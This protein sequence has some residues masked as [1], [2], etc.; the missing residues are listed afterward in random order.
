[1]KIRYYFV[2]FVCL[3]CIAN[4]FN[5]YSSN[6]NTHLINQIKPNPI[7]RSKPTSSHIKLASVQFLGKNDKTLYY[8]CT[9]GWVFD[10]IKGG[11]KA[12]ECNGYPYAAGSKQAE[13]CAQQEV[14]LSGNDVK[15][16]CLECKDNLEKDGVGGCRCNT[17]D[18]P[19]NNKNAPCP[20]NASFD[21][22]NVCS[23]LDDNGNSI[24]HYAGC[25]CPQSW[26]ICLKSNHHKGVGEA[27]KTADKVEYHVSCMCE[28]EYNLTC[29]D[30][31][32]APANEFDKCEDMG[33]IKY[34]SCL[35]CNPEE[36]KILEKNMN[37]YWC[38]T[39]GCSF[40]IDWIEMEAI[41]GVIV[42]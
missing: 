6:H 13:M 38:E 27:C 30:Y 37:K 35:Y 34:Q 32:Q 16:K 26:Q 33:G 19:Y 24:M 23:V 25:V 42:N 18:Y 28:S 12:K 3:I 11:C 39:K 1:M 15:I 22:S 5:A 9:G 4:T 31:Y 2:G 7:T 36:G 10:T 40:C 8:N 14:C 21:T 29:A 41:P 20:S 17:A